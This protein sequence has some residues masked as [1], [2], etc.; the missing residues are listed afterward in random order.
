MNLSDYPTPRTTAAARDGYTFNREDIRTAIEFS[1]DMEREAAAWRD[2]ATRLVTE[3]RELDW[4]AEQA[5]SVQ[6]NNAE[7]AIEAYDRLLTQTS[8]SEPS[9][10]QSASADVEPRTSENNEH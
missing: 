5:G 7:L 4:L 8:N 1:E 9:G 6:P 2:V 10:Q 3:M